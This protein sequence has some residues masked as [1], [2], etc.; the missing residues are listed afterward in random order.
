MDVTVSAPQVPEFRT[1]MKYVGSLPEYHNQVGCVIADPADAGRFA[2]F[3]PSGWI[4]RS[5]RW[6]SLEFVT[7]RVG[8][9]QC[10][11]GRHS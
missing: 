8:N 5:V 11:C 6:T 9:V 4:L 7:L 1:L 2:V 3:L 10:V